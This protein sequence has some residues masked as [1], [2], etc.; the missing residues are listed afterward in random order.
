[1]VV[2]GVP[3]VLGHLPNYHRLAPFYLSWG[4]IK[5]RIK[6]RTCAACVEDKGIPC[7]L[8]KVLQGKKF[9]FLW[10]EEI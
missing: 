7:G 6:K 8:K 9:G 10:A 3:L 1:M 2:R 5:T 4:A